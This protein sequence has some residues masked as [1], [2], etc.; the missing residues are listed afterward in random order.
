MDQPAQKFFTRRTA[1]D[2]VIILAVSAAIAAPIFLSGIPSGNDLPQ[3][4]QFA[5]A[6]RDAIAS[7]DPFLGW[8][9]DTNY[10]FGDVGVRFYPP[11]SYW[12]L[13]GVELV[14]SNWYDASVLTFA[15]WFF[16]GG[17]GIYFLAREWF[18]H[19][20]SLAASLAFTLMPY[21]VNQI[22]NAFLYAEFAGTAILPFCFLFAG[23]VCR[24]GDLRD[25]LGLSLSFALL[26]LT[27]LP[28]TV[29][30]AISLFIFS[31]A[32]LRSKNWTTAVAKLA[33][34]VAIGLLASS[35]YWIK[36]V[37][38]FDRVK[39]ST[40]DYS[41]GVFGFHSNFLLSYFFA[42]AAEYAD[43]SL[44]FVDLILAATIAIALPG[45]VVYYYSTRATSDRGPIAVA[46]IFL[47]SL[48][49]A[50]PLSVP[51]WEHLD[52]LARTQFPWR[53][54]SVTSLAGAILFA[55]GIQSYSGYL[56]TRA[57]PIVLLCFGLAL[58]GFAF[59]LA[60][61]V[62]PAVFI[63][64]EAFEAK[65]NELSGS[66]N[67]ECLWPVW[68][69]KE[70]LM[71]RD[72]VSASG[73]KVEAETW[74]RTDR[75]IRM[76]KGSDSITRIATFYYPNWKASVAGTEISVMA[77]NDG[78]MLLSVPP[79]SSTIRIWFEEPL[80]VRLAIIISILTWTVC[81]LGLVSIFTLD[82]RVRLNSPKTQKTE[83]FDIFVVRSR[84]K[85]LK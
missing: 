81:I 51:L 75:T 79:E 67:C 74:G 68:A 41:A 47:A 5:I 7:G 28:L 71:N 49:V 39:V 64:R 3:H 32:S 23:R 9:A 59:T 38:E 33:A 66:E 37:S 63:P 26:V 52:I 43:R 22:Y 73:R 62:R 53:W 82:F 45:A 14:T 36:V 17:L 40:G 13:A 19:P 44:L 25:I 31:I 61:V 72:L 78:S 15:L 76:S 8:S 48:I 57:R 10:G 6:Y 80:I 70:A 11:F 55:A 84:P 20:A 2:L 29:I 1:I 58:V 56:K 4:Y 12:V 30:G 46:A 65:V 27:H 77:G 85:L 60:Q 54:L 69:S 24:R 83:P 42:T 34:S 50:T 16:I 35:L 18:D 21:H